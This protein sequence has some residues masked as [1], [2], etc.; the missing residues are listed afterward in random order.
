MSSNY[1]SKVAIV[2]AGGRSG[3]PMAEELLKTGKHT[4]TAITR[5]DSTSPLPEGVQVAKVNYD[6]EA[7]LVEALKGHDALVITMGAQA[8]RDSQSKLIRAAAE[9]GVP[10]VLPN[11]WSPDTT[12]KDLCKDVFI[13][14]K[15]AATRE[16]IKKLG[17]S[18]YLSVVTGFWYEWSLGI[19]NAYGFDFADK[20]VTLFD[21]GETKMNTSTWPQVGRAVAALLSLPIQADGGK[22]EACLDHYRDRTVFVS[23][24]CVS[25]RDMLASVLRVTGDKESDWTIKKESAVERFEAAKEGMQK[26]DRMAFARWMYTRVFYPDGS[27]EYGKTKGLANGVLNLPEEDVDEATKAA[28]ERAKNN[29]YA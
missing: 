11:E 6:D 14:G 20:T 26:G 5:H 22:K 2:G 9:A 3:G 4:V 18:S 21:E 27:G 23:S 19:S 25:Q 15:A 13:F 7:T 12:N 8:P 16:E 28:M 17:K 1:I 24:F 29:P 10:W